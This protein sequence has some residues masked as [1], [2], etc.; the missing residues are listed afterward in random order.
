MFVAILQPENTVCCLTP[1]GPGAVAVLQLELAS[2]E[3]AAHALAGFRPGTAGV[4]TFPVECAPV[5]RIL[6]GQWRGEDVLLIRT[7]VSRWELHC[8]GGTAAIRRILSDLAASEVP[9]VPACTALI[10]GSGH[11]ASPQ[12]QI[13]AAVQRSLAFCRTRQ[14]ADW[15]LRQLDGRLL[16]PVTHLRTGN[17]ACRSETRT[18]LLQHAAFLTLLL[19]PAR[20][21]LFGPPNAGKSSLLNALCGL[22]RAIVSPVAGTTRDPVEA[23][24]QV[25]GRILWI[26][27]TAGLHEHPESVLEADGIRRT[28]DLVTLCDAACVLAPADQ[29]LPDVEQLAAPFSHCRT[30]ILVRSRSD[31]Q[32]DATKAT[33]DATAAEAS[34]RQQVH[35]FFSR[36]IFVSA[37]T[38]EGIN[39]LRRA[40]RDTLFPAEPDPSTALP[41]PGLID[42]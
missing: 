6:F 4:L 12:Q 34:H 21:G 9:E 31:L 41:L 3:R 14:A 1:A 28:R 42:A 26:T 36:E 23:E 27:D 25:D 8:H 40:L 35:R 20:L 7:A 24:T 17:L 33:N 2:P 13:E 29:A 37:V 5:N 18:R 10:P 16:E 11:A 22:T 38:G 19:R 32:A 39:D 15:I 30:R